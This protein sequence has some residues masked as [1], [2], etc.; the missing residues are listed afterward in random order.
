[1]ERIWYFFVLF[2]IFIYFVFIYF[3]VCYWLVFFIIFLYY[4][5]YKVYLWYLRKEESIVVLEGYVRTVNCVYWN[6]KFFGMLVSVFDDG[7]VRIWGFVERVGKYRVRDL[8]Y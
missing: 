6:F 3:L 4:V 2:V 8:I 1:M 5:D 7:I